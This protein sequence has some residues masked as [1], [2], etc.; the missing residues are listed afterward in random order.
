MDQ[1]RLTVVH[2]DDDRTEELRAHVQGG[3]FFGVGSA[4]FASSTLDAFCTSLAAY[5]I[6]PNCV[7]YIAG[8]YWEDSGKDLKETHLAICV[9][10]YDSLGALQVS[11]Q[12]AEPAGMNEHPNRGRS[13][14]TW[15]VVGYNDLQVFQA[16][17]AKVLQGYADEAI[18]TTTLV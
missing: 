7:P 13:V 3:G 9:A 14:S 6:D 17:F 11:I 4:W 15:F 12:L 1:L 10:P 8:G 18:L 2:R 5:P 16:A